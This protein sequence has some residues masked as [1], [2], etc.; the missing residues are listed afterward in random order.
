MIDHF[1]AFLNKKKNIYWKGF[2]RK[3]R[4]LCIYEIENIVNRYGAIVDFKMFSDLEISIKI[5]IAEQRIHKLYTDLI[6]QIEIDDCKDLK[7]ESN[8]E[9]TILLNVTFLQGTG[10]LEIEGPIGPG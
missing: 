10:D 3:N 5:E 1:W 7:S 9:R 6:E 2:C 8:T 4:N